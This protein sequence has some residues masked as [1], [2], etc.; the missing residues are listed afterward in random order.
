M[1]IVEM[2][3]GYLANKVAGQFCSLFKTNVI[4]RWSRLRA[5]EFVATFC[6]AVAD[7]GNPDD[8]SQLLDDMMA[9]EKKTAAL[10][11]AY[12]RVALSTSMTIGPRIIALVTARAIA[13]SRDVSPAEDQIMAV[14]ELLTD[15]EFAEAKDWY[16][17]YV[18]KLEQPHSSFHD[19]G[20]EDDVASTDLWDGW[21]AWAAKLGQCG[22]ITHSIR[23]IANHNEY[24]G[25]VEMEKPRLATDMH[26]DRAYADLASLI[27][28]ASHGLNATEPSDAPKSR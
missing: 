11:D 19:P 23:I 1:A 3:G 17:R 14:S 25:I 20:H 16:D 21:G 15:A 8:V 18:V 12:R 26:Y 28:L 9:D 22:F 4:E 6:N 2:V 13:E 5:E 24:D 10:F 27:D 7:G